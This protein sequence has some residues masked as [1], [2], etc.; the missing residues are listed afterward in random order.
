MTA[1]AS[2]HHFFVNIPLSEVTVKKEGKTE[3]HKEE[4]IQENIMTRGVVVPWEEFKRDDNL[5]TFIG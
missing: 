4:G 3:F 5:C 2:L 1:G